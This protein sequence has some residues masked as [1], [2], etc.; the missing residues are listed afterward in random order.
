[1]RE[2]FFKKPLSLDEAP[3][4]WVNVTRK[5]TEGEAKRLEESPR[6][7]NCSHLE[8]FHVSSCG[9]HTHCSI[10]DCGCSE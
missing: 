5:F 3:V 6:C 10:E 1:M 9:C 2:P 7:I 4:K 8:V